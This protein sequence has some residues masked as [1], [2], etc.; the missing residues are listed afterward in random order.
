MPIYMEIKGIDGTAEPSNHAGDAD[1]FSF[2]PS[3]TESGNRLYVGNLTMD[4][5]T[6]LAG[7]GVH[8]SSDLA[9][10]GDRA[11]PNELSLT[12]AGDPVVLGDGEGDIVT[13]NRGQDSAMYLD[14]VLV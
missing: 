5:S 12:D 2:D 3:V 11:E 13:I 6:D 14:G 7:S 4:S 10:W 1:T 9:F 8:T